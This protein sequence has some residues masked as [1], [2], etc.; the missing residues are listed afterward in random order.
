MTRLR[1]APFARAGRSRSRRCCADIRVSYT[2]VNGRCCESS[3]GS[4]SARER[5]G[6]PFEESCRS[7][8]ASSG[9]RAARN[10]RQISSSSSQSWRSGA[11][12]CIEEAL[13]HV[14][15][16]DHRGRHAESTPRN[17]LR[18]PLWPLRGRTRARAP[19]RRA[20]RCRCDRNP[21]ESKPSRRKSAT[22]VAPARHGS[23]RW[24]RSGPGAGPREGVVV[25]PC[26]AAG[27]GRP[28]S[29]RAPAAT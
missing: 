4:R 18:S 14:G 25:T 17:F 11:G 16:E 13:E 6:G 15:P 7:R 1:R 29:R 21:C 22:T 23:R 28:R 2:P 19:C 24:R 5:E 10:W 12:R 27:H 20:S 9:N 3:R 8:S 26:A